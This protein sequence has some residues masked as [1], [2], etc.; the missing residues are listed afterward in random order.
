[1]PYFYRRRYNRY[2]RRRWPRPW[3]FR[4]A[5][6]RRRR[7][8]K[9]RG[10]RRK[11]ARLS[12]KEWQ[13]KTIRK[14]CIKGLHCMFI[15]TE[16]TISRNFRMY[17]HSIIPEKWPGG[18]GFSVTR[19]S[20]DGLYEQHQLDRNW[21]TNTNKN[22]PLVRYTGCKI[23]FYQ[24][25]SVDYVCNYSLDY[26]MVATGLL[27]L[28]CQPNFML[29]NNKKI[30]VPSKLT[31]PT[32]KGYITVKFR[33]PNLMS[34]RWFFAKDIAKTG[35]LMLTV[36]A[37]SLDNYYIATDKTSNNCTFTS[38]NSYFWKQHNFI[39]P[40][41]FGYSPSIV[42]TVQKKIFS[43]TQQIT[44]TTDLTKKK[45]SELGLTY[46]GTTKTYTEGKQISNTNT[47]YFT[48]HTN[49]GNPFTHENLTVGNNLLTTNKGIE[50][51][52]EQLITNYDK[53]LP[54][55]FFTKPT[56]PLLHKVRYAPDRD[57]GVGNK[58]YLKSVLR[59]DSGWEPPSNE[60]LICEG[61]P[62]WA[63]LY[64]FLDWQTKLAEATNIKRSYVLVI[65]SSFL[66]PKLPY[67][68]P[69]DEDFIEGV[70]PYYDP[71]NTPHRTHED[72]QNWY[73]CTLYQYKSIENIIRTGPGIPKL[74]T[75]KAVEAKILYNFYFKFGG[76]PPKMDMVA[77]P[78]KQETYPIPNHKSST[79]SLQNP[80]IP[81]E[82]YLY[83]FDVQQD[84][85]TKR[86][87]KRIK[88]YDSTPKLLFSTSGGMD[89]PAFTEKEAEGTSPTASDEEEDPTA[90]RIRIRQLKRQRKHLEQQ[91]QLIMEQP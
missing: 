19:Y 76:C 6:W 71:N 67:Y 8:R 51:L 65:E 44:D 16:Q 56:E 54:A 29:M 91:I 86:A 21:W 10:V 5:F 27:Y 32:K 24:S 87:A 50:D 64:G 80:S 89:T 43:T 60:N 22:L 33:P 82:T 28:S 55:G 84:I 12:I 69:I 36:S 13:P 81:Q 3:R 9:R 66:D 63:E 74:G 31:K 75:R 46:L 61:F 73:P 4:K 41:I 45:P 70:S 58:V 26:P 15:C 88:S 38:L 23:R 37:T 11:K 79:Y 78:T 1:M 72:D 39:Q 42:G 34:N 48:E 53:T 2:R 77:D 59:D 30:V 83:Q 25:H 14:C 49:W 20:L 18:G 85:I 40:S 62:L 90:L 52:K 17:E 57:T 35:L 7:W 68:I 47:N